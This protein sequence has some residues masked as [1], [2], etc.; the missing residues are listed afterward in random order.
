VTPSVLRWPVRRGR[1]TCAW[2]RLVSRSSPESFGFAG[3]LFGICGLFLIIVGQSRYLQA[4]TSANRYV[5]SDALT[6]TNLRQLRVL[7]STIGC[8]L[9]IT[10]T[11]A[12]AG[13]GQAGVSSR[14]PAAISLLADVVWSAA[15]CAIAPVFLL[16]ADAVSPGIL[17]RSFRRSIEFVFI[18]A[19]IAWPLVVLLQTSAWGLEQGRSLFLYVSF[20]GLV[21]L[22]ASARTLLHRRWL[23]SAAHTSC[24]LVS[25]PLFVTLVLFIALAAAPWALG[26]K[27]VIPSSVMI[28]LGSLVPLTLVYSTLQACG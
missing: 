26:S 23:C 18:A 28:P 2:R 11:L 16:L 10:S 24:F 22:F 21:A 7:T 6:A 19:L 8:S 15:F 17:P 3:V 20:I 13:L 12:L 4:L 5:I 1:A 9:L 27:F 14:T 25:L